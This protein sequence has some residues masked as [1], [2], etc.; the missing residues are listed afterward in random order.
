MIVTLGSLCLSFVCF[1]SQVPTSIDLI[2]QYKG[3]LL[4]VT[5]YGQFK[6]GFLWVLLRHFMAYKV[7]LEV[8]LLKLCIVYIIWV[9]SG[10][11]IIEKLKPMTLR[12][13][14]HLADIPQ[15]LI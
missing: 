7:C 11:F 6:F 3:K 8:N 12:L 9:G 1:D 15:L 5:L 14:S 10:P 13:F 2:S 4:S